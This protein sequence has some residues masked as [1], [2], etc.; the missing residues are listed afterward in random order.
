[1][2]HVVTGEGRDYRNKQPSKIFTRRYFEKPSLQGQ[3]KQYNV[4]IDNKDISEWL[5]C[6]YFD[7]SRRN[8][9]GF[10]NTTD[11]VTVAANDYF[12]IEIVGGSAHLLTYKNVTCDFLCETAVNIIGAANSAYYSFTA[13]S[14]ARAIGAMA[15]GTT[16]D[17]TTT[18]VCPAASTWENLRGYVELNSSANTTNFY[19]RIN[20]AN[21]NQTF[22]VTGSATGAFSDETNTDTLAAGDDINILIDEVTTSSLRISHVET[23]VVNDT[24]G[25]VS[26]FGAYTAGTQATNTTRYIRPIGGLSSIDATETSAEIVLRGSGTIS[27]FYTKCAVNGLDR[28]TVYTVRKNNADTSITFTV[29]AS[30]TGEYSDTT[31]SFTYSDGDT[32]CL[33]SVTASGGTGSITHGTFSFLL[34][35]DVETIGGGGTVIPVFMNQY[36]QRSA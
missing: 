32:F 9:R 25:T 19:S 26:C 22:Q 17:N 31:N 6:T 1:L 15:S 8:Y 4:R 5:C 14:I 34:T 21:G 2:P 16:E 11:S 3:R 35:P 7:I 12:S 18:I 10:E 20:S 28:D 27:K 29:P 33:K 23:D 36:R 30:T 13:D 24:A